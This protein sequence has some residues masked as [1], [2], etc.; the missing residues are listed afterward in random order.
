[1]QQPLYSLD[2][3]VDGGLAVVGV[4][5]AGERVVGSRGHEGE[6]LLHLF[7]WFE[8]YAR[9][10]PVGG[11]AGRRGQQR[12]PSPRRPPRGLGGVA[13]EGGGRRLGNGG[14]GDGGRNPEKHGAAVCLCG[15]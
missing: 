7:E 1:M 14:G 11:D 4:L 9:E 15:E 13:P 5:L 12:R 10:C 6:L 8:D 2:L 3:P